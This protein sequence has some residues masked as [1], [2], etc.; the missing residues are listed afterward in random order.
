MCFRLGPALRPLCSLTRRVS[1]TH[2]TRLPG[3]NCLCV[4][5]GA[6]EVCAGH[7]SPFFT[8]RVNLAR[9]ISC[10]WLRPCPGLQP[11]LSPQEEKS[12]P[13][14]TP[15]PRT[16]TKLRKLFPK[17]ALD[18]TDSNMNSGS[19]CAPLLERENY[20]WY[21]ETSFMKLLI[22]L[23][24]RM[25]RGASIPHQPRGGICLALLT[26]FILDGHVDIG[27]A[28][29][30]RA[31]SPMN[32]DAR[33]GQCTP[34]TPAD[35]RQRQHPEAECN[36]NKKREK[37]A[38][39]RVGRKPRDSACQHLQLRALHMW[40][41]PG[42]LSRLGLVGCPGYFRRMGVWRRVL[43]VRPVN[44]CTYMYMCGDGS[45]SACPHGFFGVCDLCFVFCVL[46]FVLCA[47]CFVLCALCFVLCALCFVLCAVRCALCVL[48]VVC[49][50]LCV[51]CCVLCVC[52]FVCL[53]VC[54]MCAAFCLCVCSSR[55]GLGTSI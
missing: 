47:L 49:C 12:V 44:V 8:L 16:R 51:V 55:V 29:A 32:T 14:P 43:R 5:G 28:F 41:A 46:C 27:H 17:Q 38:A 20:V 45:I 52:V 3:K 13:P 6:C 11:Q 9:G 48:C 19:K 34:L 36:V 42:V 10:L 30:C 21:F 2:A 18:P 15:L 23:R 4:M 22:P 54:V 40:R 35:R 7:S 39:L 24:P 53:C 1:T 31:R 26:A 25:S 37:R 50:V 33:L